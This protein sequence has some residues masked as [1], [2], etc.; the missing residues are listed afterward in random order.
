MP[1][2]LSNLECETCTVRYKSFFFNLS[3]SDLQLL[4][5]SKRCTI[6]EKG[7][8]LFEEGTLPFGLYGI[9]SGKVKLSKASDD[10]KEQIIYLAK[11][12]DVLGY[13][14]ILSD[15]VYSCTATVI[16]DATICFIP[17]EVFHQMVES[18]AELSSQV[19]KSLSARLKI[20]EQ[21]M[22]GLA[23]KQ[24]RERLAE[25]LLFLREVYGVD[26][27]KQAINLNLTREELA[28]I[29]GTATET[30][31]RLLS[32]FKQDNIIDIEGKRITILNMKQLV[33]I[34]NLSF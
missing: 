33:R 23:Q 5:C 20:V 18:N 34:A 1:K 10:G 2:K 19:I 8:L 29:V 14:A 26:G 7:Q 27:E 11:E 22:T 31:I 28:N 17:R 30:V 32:E 6:Y 4:N 16:D 9:S 24:V 21:S 12:G 13:R 15:D 25:T 3:N